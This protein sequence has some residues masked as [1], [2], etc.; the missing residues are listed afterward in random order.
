MWEADWGKIILMN[1]EPA[2][3]YTKPSQNVKEHALRNNFHGSGSSKT[4]SSFNVGR[5]MISQ[6]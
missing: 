2:L 5:M 3:N 6:V 4:K 1:H